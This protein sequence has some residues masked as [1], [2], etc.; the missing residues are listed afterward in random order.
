MQ[1][2]LDCECG[3]QVSVGEG[4][5]GSTRECRCGRTLV[6]PSL[7]ELRRQAGLRPPELPIEKVVETLLLAGKLPEEHTCILCGA[8][9]DASICCTTEC[10]RAYVKS[11]QPPWYVYVLGYIT[12]GW[13]GVAIA[14]TSGEDREW[15][16]DRVFPLPLR[17]CAAC[18]PR[19]TSPADLKDAMMRVRLYRRLL[20][21]YPD[22]RVSLASL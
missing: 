10:E 15:G 18:R 17:V 19:L 20:A 16:T 1:Y 21:K 12:F 4:A 8:L 3:D 11:G 13:V 22:A 5:A 7:D 14:S 9:T 6:V 2:Q